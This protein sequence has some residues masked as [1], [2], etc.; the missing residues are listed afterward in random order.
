[1]HKMLNFL[2]IQVGNGEPFNELS[3]D[4]GDI[5]RDLIVTTS[6]HESQKV[7]IPYFIERILYL[8]HTV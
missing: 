4:Q 1:V 5:I 8:H 3:I 2:E 7:Q 6:E